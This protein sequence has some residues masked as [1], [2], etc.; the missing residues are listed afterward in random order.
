ML[1]I[2][3]ANGRCRECDSR[4]VTIGTLPNNDI[5][6]KDESV[7]STALRADQ[8]AGDVWLRD[9]Q[10]HVGTVA[11]GRRLVGRMFLDGWHEVTVGRV[12]LRVS[13]RSDLLV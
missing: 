12:Q 10:S 9:L 13:A 6:L 4:I 8:F 1:T 5:V 11:D 2:E 7:Q 3:A